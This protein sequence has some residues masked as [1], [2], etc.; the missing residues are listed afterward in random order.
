MPSF[1]RGIIITTVRPGCCMAWRWRTRMAWWPRITRRWSSSIT[2]STP[3]TEWR[4][5]EDYQTRKL[6]KSNTYSENHEIQPRFWTKW[7]LKQ[8]MN[9][10]YRFKNTSPVNILISCHGMI[11]M[12]KTS[13]YFPQILKSV[14]SKNA[15]DLLILFRFTSEQ[16]NS[17]H[18]APT[19]LERK[20]TT[21]RKRWKKNNDI[22]QPSKLSQLK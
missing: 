8:I 12:W 13:P 2:N 15:S 3:V 11:G 5:F 19:Q 18:W 4:H 7:A 10:I 14:Q 22:Q 16:N 1:W 6:W 20:N 21:G 17:N 9:T